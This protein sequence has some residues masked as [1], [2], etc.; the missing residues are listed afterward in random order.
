MIIY[1]AYTK[2]NGWTRDYKR[3]NGELLFNHGQGY[4]KAKNYCTGFELLDDTDDTWSKQINREKQIAN[5]LDEDYGYLYTGHLYKYP[6]KFKISYYEL[7]E[8]HFLIRYDKGVFYFMYRYNKTTE[9]IPISY[10]DE[11]SHQYIDLDALEYIGNVFENEEMVDNI[12]Y[13]R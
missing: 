1:K 9:R 13:E 11:I 3:E 2:Q 8:P 5:V 10:I 7:D 12:F 4:V 6:H